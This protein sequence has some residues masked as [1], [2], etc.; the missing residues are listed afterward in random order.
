MNYLAINVNF[1]FYLVALGA[2]FYLKSN[3]LS[4]A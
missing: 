3:S 1:S 2:L 4:V